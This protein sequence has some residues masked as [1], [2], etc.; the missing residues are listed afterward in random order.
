MKHYKNTLNE[1]F[2]YEADGSQDHI[3]PK[4]TLLS[5]MQKLIK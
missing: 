2:A 3:I 4:I 1:I 5:L